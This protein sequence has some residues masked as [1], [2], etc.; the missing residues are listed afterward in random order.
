MELDNIIV[1]QKMRKGGTG[2][3]AVH[4]FEALKPRCKL[5]NMGS[6][7]WPLSRYIFLCVIMSALLTY[8]RGPILGVSLYGKDFEAVRERSVASGSLYRFQL[9]EQ[10]T[11]VQYAYKPVLAD[12]VSVAFGEIEDVLVMVCCESDP[13]ACKLIVL[14]PGQQRYLCQGQ[15]AIPSYL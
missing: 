7:L 15:D 8:R 3:E 1:N 4:N 6:I 10:E 5:I 12:Y 2:G 13:S 11:Y 9:T 14:C